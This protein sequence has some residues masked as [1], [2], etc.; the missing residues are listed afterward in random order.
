MFEIRIQ[1]TAE[2]IT[3]FGHSVSTLCIFAPQSFAVAIASIEGNLSG[4]TPDMVD[5]LAKLAILREQ[6]VHLCLVGQTLAEK[7]GRSE[8]VR[9]EGGPVQ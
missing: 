7:I 3:P 9:I 4:D 6:A 5:A 1:L 2:Q 8:P